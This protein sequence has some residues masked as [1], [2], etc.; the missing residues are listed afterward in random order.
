MTGKASEKT[1]QAPEVAGPSP[2]TT[3]GALWSPS[4]AVGA[5]SRGTLEENARRRQW[6]SLC[7]G[8]SVSLAPR[9]R[10]ALAWGQAEAA[11]GLS[12]A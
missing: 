1:A 11:L 6:R 9:A 8:R 4:S 7:S 3:A 12:P 2:Y 10:S 5:L